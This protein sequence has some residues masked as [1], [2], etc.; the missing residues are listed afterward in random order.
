MIRINQVSMYQS[1]YFQILCICVCAC[2]SA[3]RMRQRARVCA[4]FC[5]ECVRL[6]VPV[7]LH[8]QCLCGCICATNTCM[9]ACAWFCVTCARACTRVLDSVLRVR[10]HVRVR[11]CLCWVLPRS[12]VQ[13]FVC[14]HF[15]LCIYMCVS[16]CVC[17][18]L[19][20]C[21]SVYL[22]AWQASWNS[23]FFISLPKCFCLFS[24]CLFVCLCLSVCLP[25]LA[26]GAVCV[27]VN[28]CTPANVVNTTSIPFKE[29]SHELVI[30]APGTV[31]ASK[32]FDFLAP[33]SPSSPN[34]PVYI[35]PLCDRPSRLH[36]HRVTPHGRSNSGIDPFDE[37]LWNTTLA[38]ID[39]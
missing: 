25:Y 10:V 24:I 13:L 14:I 29:K 34:Q 1:V 37:R 19:S 9:Y 33:T 32:E 21:L 20:V 15:H 2:T 26:V 23:I 12:A 5:Y 39:K 38:L 22:T 36:N 27:H 7:R 30:T 11:G 28:T 8:C 35:N 31:V 6:V 17:L 4:H 3:S 18:Q 16:V